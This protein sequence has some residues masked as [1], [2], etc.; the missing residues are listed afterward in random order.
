MLTKINSLEREVS[1]LKRDLVASE[2]K[3]KQLE[4]KN[5]QKNSESAIQLAA[6]ESKI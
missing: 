5:E 3:L 6:A 2:T 1:K 4:L